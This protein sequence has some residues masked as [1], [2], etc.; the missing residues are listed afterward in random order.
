M[1]ISTKKISIYLILAVLFAGVLW[2]VPNAGAQGV[3][4][5]ASWSYGQYEVE[6]DGQ[7][8][9]D[10]SYFTQRYSLYF[11]K[12]GQINGGRGGRYNLGLG[13]EW[14]SLKSEINDEDFDV[15]ASKFLYRG[16]VLIA[17]GGLPFRLHLFSYDNTS[18]LFNSNT[19]SSALGNFSGSS[20]LLDVGVPVDMYNGQ[21]IRTG[22]TL[23]VGIRNGS[24]MGR[25]RE[26]LSQFPRLLID[27]QEDYIRDLNGLTPQHSRQRNLA[28]VSLNK[29]DNW[30]HYRYSDYDDFLNPNQD[31][32]EKTYLLGTVDH[33]LQRKWINFTNWI[34]VSVDAMYTTSQRVNAD[35]PADRAYHLNLFSTAK[36]RNW[37]AGTFT[38][39]HRITNGERL[40]KEI[41]VPFY[42]SGE[43][44]RNTAWRF[45]FVGSKDSDN[46][47]I[48]GRQEDE[49]SLFS[50][51]Q[52]ETFR[53]SRVI[54]KPELAMELKQGDRGEGHAVKLGTEVY[55]N[56]AYRSAYDLFGGFSL[57][58]FGGTSIE[59][60]DV[61]YW[62]STVI[63]RGETK[64]SSSVR[65]GIEQRLL[66]GTG[67]IDRDVANHITPLGDE[68]LV[69]SRSGNETREGNVFRSTSTWFGEHLSRFRLN[70]RA[71]VLYDILNTEEE[72]IDQ[73]I[74]RL[75]MRYDGSNFLVSTRNELI[76]GD[77]Q[78]STNGLGSDDNSLS[79]DSIGAI[80]TT[81]LHS[82]SLRYSPSRIWEASLMVDY[83]WR[84]G[85]GGNQTRASLRQDFRYNIYS[86][87]AIVRK[88]VQLEEELRYERYWGKGASFRNTEFTLTGTYFPSRLAFLAAKFRYRD[89]DEFDREDVAGLLSAAINFNKLTLSLEYGYGTL[90]ASDEVSDITEQR[91]EARVKKVF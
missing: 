91:W 38:N 52:I 51:A 80:Q 81:F 4:G 5:G 39:F 65:S 74:L 21:R 88:L 64:L 78:T 10:A 50:S 40:Q 13:G 18:I 57:A 63:T 61:D 15:D 1:R 8:V 24:Y 58:Q 79:G 47:F 87:G 22:A 27:Y 70:S 71:E 7:K 20:S 55:T 19:F 62:E 60:T 85:D 89:S 42:A 26:M 14:A 69:A 77:N 35:D 6:E 48:V 3:S 25:Y 28:F 67:T 75:S 29:K 84:D 86:T 44:N 73:L 49:D 66:Y 17:P 72:T 16:E 23:M 43:P 31:F 9:T 68:S 30:F 45:R 54:L 76:Y 41:E 2:V 46:Q 37:K 33:T 34:K 56:K 53:R 36:Q 90:L 82:S 11:N 59:G 32:L 12:K 83:D